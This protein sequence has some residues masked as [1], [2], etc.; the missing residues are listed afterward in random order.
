MQKGKKKK[1]WK[2]KQRERQIRWQRS[3]EAHEIRMERMA[4]ERR[5]QKR[6]RRIF[7]GICLIALILIVYGVWEYYVR[8]PP[9]ISSGKI[10]GPLQKGSA[11]IFSLRDVAGTQFSLDQ[12]VGKIIIIHFMAVGCNGQI[13]PLNQE[14][15]SQL[16]AVCSRYCGKKPF[17]MVTVAVATCENSELQKIRA[18]YGISWALGNDYDDKKMDIVDAYVNACSIKDG[19]IVVIDKAFTIAEVYDEAMTADKLSARISQLLET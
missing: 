19:A 6:T 11:P 2:E 3:H 5:Q 18:N 7:S 16:K 1:S 17:A 4:E 13:Y 12:Q 8:L 9:S 10:S 15:L 14:R